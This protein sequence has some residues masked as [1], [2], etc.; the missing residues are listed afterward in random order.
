M[1][2][3]KKITTGDMPLGIWIAWEYDGPEMQKKYVVCDSPYYDMDTTRSKKRDRPRKWCPGRAAPE[4]VDTPPQS[5]DGRR[6]DG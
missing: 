5:E 6:E 2:I 1:G 3:I 4:R